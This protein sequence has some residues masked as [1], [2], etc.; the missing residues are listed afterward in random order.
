MFYYTNWS[1]IRRRDPGHATNTTASAERISTLRPTCAANLS[2]PAATDDAT[3]NHHQS[4]EPGEF[5]DSRTPPEAPKLLQYHAHR[6]SRHSRRSGYSTVLYLEL[7]HDGTYLS[8]Y[9]STERQHDILHD[10]C[11]QYYDELFHR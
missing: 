11:H 3:G 1:R 2:I 4:V 8:G 10:E 5:N 9:Y 6:C 7:T